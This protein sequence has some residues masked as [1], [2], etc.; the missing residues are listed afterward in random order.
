MG[1]LVLGCAENKKQKNNKIY[2]SG[3]VDIRTYV[4]TCV[5]TYV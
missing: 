5:C 3:W 1:N 2:M 4:R